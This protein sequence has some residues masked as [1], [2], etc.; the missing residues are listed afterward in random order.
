MMAKWS[1]SCWALKEGASRSPFTAARTPLRRCLR[2]DPPFIYCAAEA[3]WRARQLTNEQWTGIIRGLLQAF[4]KH[5]IVVHGAAHAVEEFVSEPRVLCYGQ[6]TVR[7]LFEKFR[8]QTWSSLPIVLPCTWLRSTTCPR[9]AISVQPILTAS[10]QPARAAPAF[11]TNRLVPHA[12]SFEAT[13]PA[14]GD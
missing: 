5:T 2:P 11:S 14:A 4:P 6:K 7:E 8:L 12:C 3:G 10:S 13:K 9:S 1:S